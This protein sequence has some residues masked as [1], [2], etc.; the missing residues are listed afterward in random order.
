MCCGGLLGVTIKDE[1]RVAS[2]HNFNRML[3]VETVA[4]VQLV[5]ITL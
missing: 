3:E 5:G 2:D 4:L 1:L